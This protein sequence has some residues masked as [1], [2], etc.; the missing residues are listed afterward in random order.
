MARPASGTGT[1]WY[2]NRDSNGVAWLVFDKAETGTNVLSGQIMLEL[3]G[4]LR[5]LEENPPRAVI[6]KSAKN[7]G[8]IAGADIKEFTGLESPAQAFDLIRRGQ[9]VL[10]KLDTLPCPT[11]AAVH[12]FALGGGLELA[13]ACDYIIA[14]D[15]ERTSLGLP[16]VNLGI[17]PGFGGTVRSILKI[18][19]MPAMELMLTG[20]SFNVRKA[21]ATGLVDKAVP[22]DELDAAATGYALNPPAPRRAPLVQRLLNLPGAR[23]AFAKV[24]E[25]QVAAKARKDHY[26]APYAIIDLWKDGIGDPSQ[27]YLAEAH[28]IANLMCGDTARNLVRVF[29]LQDRLK[30]LGNKKAFEL[31]HVHVVGAGTMGGDIAAWCAYKGFTVS[32]QD[33]ELKYIEPALKRARK[34]FEKKFKGKQPAVEEALH[35]LKADVNGD[36]AASA[37]LVIEAI[38]EN[39][40]AKQNLYRELKKKMKP[41]AVLATNTSSIRLEELAT[42]LDDPDHLVGLH[43]FNP[44]AKMLLIEV[45]HSKDTNKD[46]MEKALAFARHVDRLPVPCKSSPGFLVNRILMPYL[47][48]AMLLSEEGVAPE[49]IDRAARNFGMPMGPVEL[50]DTVGLDV[51]LSVA[52]IL[53]KEFGHA[54][55]KRLEEMVAAKKLGKKTGEGFYAYDENGKPKKDAGGAHGGPDDLQ[56]RLVFPMLNEAV[57][58]LREDVVADADL[59]DAGVIFGTGFAPFRGGPMNFIRHEG[60]ARLRERLEALHERHGDR[61]APD[62]GW[63]SLTF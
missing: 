37:D 6:V 20:R 43:F 36:G 47:M 63:H 13:L 62:A 39:T 1:N 7:S 8:F 29:L 61:F 31:R 28:S 2:L 22:L 34:L 27:M 57:A 30:G 18:G 45:I 24:L 38:F 49:A 11:V 15:D 32:L 46:V 40:E 16:E 58:C 44:V 53:G 52:N 21:V 14:A 56:D 9:L 59:L 12:G 26:P 23:H 3:E 4:C 33:R 41:E 42:V 60:V 50:A 55:P 19:V 48:E 35:R 51:C 17:H 25:K 54:V 5:E 10:D